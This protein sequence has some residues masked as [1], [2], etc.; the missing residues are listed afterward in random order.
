MEI[1]QSYDLVHKE[2]V[3]FLVLTIEEEGVPWY[4][5]IMKFLELGV[6]PNNVDKRECCLVRMMA[7]QYILYGGQLYK[8]S[9]DGIHLHFLKKEEAERVMEEVHQGICGP[10]MNGRMLAKKIPMMGY[11]WNTMEIDYVDSVKSCHDCQTYANLN[12]VPPG[13]LYSTT[14]PWPFSVWGIDM[15]ERIASKV[16]NGHEYILMAID[17]FIK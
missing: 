9:Y 6:Y 16:S 10:H 3:E 12:H 2:K 15:I 17:Y 14:S 7:M 8:R 1:E 5:D 4:Y 11:N 13:E